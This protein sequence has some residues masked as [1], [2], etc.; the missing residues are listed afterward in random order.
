MQ[1]IYI[2][3]NWHPSPLI[4]TEAC[5][6]ITARDFY[7]THAITRKSKSSLQRY[8]WLPVDTKIEDTHIMNEFDSPKDLKP[9]VGMKKIGY[10]V[11][12]LFVFIPYVPVQF[13]QFSNNNSQPTIRITA[14]L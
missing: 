3:G 6:D 12:H 4:S 10:L 5:V 8:L 7:L 9:L 1:H 13:I 2:Y 14:V 11:L